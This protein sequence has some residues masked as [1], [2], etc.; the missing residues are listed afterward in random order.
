MINMVPRDMED[1]HYRY[2][3]K[4]HNRVQKIRDN[5]AD[6]KRKFEAERKE[7]RDRRHLM[8]V[9]RTKRK[10]KEEI[11]AKVFTKKTVEP[12]I[13][14]L[15]L[16]DFMDDDQEQKKFRTYGGFLYELW[17][18]LSFSRWMFYKRAETP[19]DKFLLDEDLRKF[20]LSFMAE[21]MLKDKSMRIE[22]NSKYRHQF[23]EA[24]NLMETNLL[25]FN[26]QKDTIIQSLVDHPDLVVGLVNHMCISENLLDKDVLTDLLKNILRV[27][28]K[29]NDYKIPQEDH[30]HVPSDG[31]VRPD[32]SSLLN[33]TSNP[34]NPDRN[35][36][37]NPSANMEQSVNPKVNVT[38]NDDPQH[39]P[40][41]TDTSHQNI[42]GNSL[43]QPPGEIDPNNP[44]ISMNRRR[45]SFRKSPFPEITDEDRRIETLKKKLDIVFIN[46]E[47]HERVPEVNAVFRIRQSLNREE[48][49]PEVK[50]QREE[51]KERMMAEKA[52]IIDPKGE[53]D[54]HKRQ[55]LYEDYLNHIKKL[56]EE[57]KIKADEAEEKRK[58]D[59]IEQYYGD[60]YEIEHRVH[61]FEQAD[62]PAT[63]INETTQLNGDQRVLYI[64][65]VNQSLY[66]EAIFEKLRETF[67]EKMSLIKDLK[68]EKETTDLD[69]R[70][71]EVVLGQI[72]R[73][74]D[75]TPIF[76]VE[77]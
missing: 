20:I 68:I 38:V 66:R 32:Q 13:L 49:R 73:Q 31:N 74:K 76:D 58:N 22:F 25:S 72:V 43:L 44:D 35:Q 61:D 52:A 27:F 51:E 36:I 23:D 47:E 60:S 65:K 17:T 30:S 62:R 4:E 18:V 77:L 56:E 39:S 15:K 21:P 59:Y 67:R 34:D 24:I 37:P 1:I 2:L 9:A 63:N 29:S 6:K 69:K 16:V 12:D 48:I 14:S 53:L 7:R 11:E 55:Y 71:E 10:L 33:D 64:N 3:E 57:E 46:R 26:E 42:T 28:F 54:Y 8:R 70:V 40:P 45:S 5:E 75:Q 41:Q 50:T 19:L